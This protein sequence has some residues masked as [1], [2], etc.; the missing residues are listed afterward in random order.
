MSASVLRPLCIRY[1]GAGMPGLVG[2]FVQKD[3]RYHNS[4][5]DYSAKVMP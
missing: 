2:P 4:T 5:M 1:P 3:A